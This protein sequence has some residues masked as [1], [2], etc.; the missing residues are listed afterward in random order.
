MQVYINIIIYRY[1]HAIYIHT[2]QTHFVCKYNEILPDFG[3]KK[4]T[5]YM[6]CAITK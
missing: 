5:V 2:N 4:I 6:L 3:E 1:I